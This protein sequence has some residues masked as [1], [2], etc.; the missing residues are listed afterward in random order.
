[1]AV[2]PIDATPGGADSNSFIDEAFADQ[3]LED[4]LNA[5]AWAA[6][7]PDNRIRALMEATRELTRLAWIGQR[8]DEVQAL[9]WPRFEAIDP[10][11]P[12]S[13][14][15]FGSISFYPD[16]EIPDRI[17]NA[18]AEY[19]L[20]FIKSGSVDV[21]A[22][23]PSAGIKRTKVD[24]LETEYFSPGGTTGGA[25]G[26]DRYPT[27]IREITPLLDDSASG[28]GSLEILRA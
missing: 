1:M 18:T 22:I 21:A 3:Y 4:R 26:L 9:S 28:A 5:E 27:V 2:T 25:E 8:T 12:L 17:Q 10:D 24:V 13:D 19:A 23:D 20:E 6:A 7:D 15:G 11:T 14:D 16:D